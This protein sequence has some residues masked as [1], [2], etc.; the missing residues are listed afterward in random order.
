[1]INVDFAHVRELMLHGGGAFMAIGLG[2]GED[3]ATK[4]IQQALNH[5]LLEIG[6][7]EQAS[8]VLVH[9]T[10]GDDLT[11]FEIGEA[12]SELRESLL[13]SADLI[14]GATTEE[15]MRG[16]TQVILVVTGIGGRPVHGLS[17]SQISSPSREEKVLLQVD[18]NDLDIP[19]F[20]RRRRSF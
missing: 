18:E 6:S 4:A 16:R 7:L 10:G 2:E 9:Y 13:P 20:M 1:L 15:A 8:G 14:L 12:V 3:K 11:L 17:K 5:P 19:A